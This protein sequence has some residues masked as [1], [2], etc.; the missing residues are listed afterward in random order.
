MDKARPFPRF[1][2]EPLKAK[3]LVNI[4]ETKRL[5]EMIAPSDKTVILEALKQLDG[6]KRH[7]H[8]VLNTL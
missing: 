4:H 1:I 7:L 5:Q 3:L 6:L 8:R 2:D